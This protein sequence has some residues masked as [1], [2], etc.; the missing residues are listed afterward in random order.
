MVKVLGG[1][2]ARMLA[3]MLVAVSVVVLMVGVLGGS[4]SGQSAA[5]AEFPDLTAPQAAALASSEFPSVV[6]DPAF[7]EPA[8]PAGGQLAFLDDHSANVVAADGSVAGVVVSSVPLRTLND[9]GHPA[10]VD[11]SLTDTGPTLEPAN[12]LVDVRVHQNLVGGVDLGGTGITLVPSGSTLASEGV[13][14][15]AVAFFANAGSDTDFLVK[16]VPAGFESFTA[17]R[18]SDSPTEVSYRFQTPAGVTAGVSGDGLRVEFRGVDGRLVASVGLPSAVDGDGNPVATSWTLDGETM[19][20]SVQHH[21]AGVVYPV[22]V[23]PEVEYEFEDLDATGWTFINPSG[24]DFHG[25]LGSGPHGR[26]LYVRTS[27]S[28]LGLPWSPFS[29]GQR[30]YWSYQ[31]QGTAKITEAEWDDLFHDKDNPQNRS[32]VQVGI[33]QS[34]LSSLWE[35]GPNA[36]DERCAKVTGQEVETS[37]GTGE[38][39]NAALAHPGNAARFGVRIT[40]SGLI[41]SFTSDVGDAEI[42]LTDSDNPTITEDDVPSAWGPWPA[43][44]IVKVSAHDGGLGVKTASLSRSGWNAGTGTSVVPA[45]CQSAA[46]CAPDYLFRLAGNAIPTVANLPAGDNVLTAS[47]TDPEQHTTSQQ[48][49]VR[50]DRIAPTLALSGALYTQRAQ[51][52]APG[53]YQL[54][55]DATDTDPPRTTS[56]VRSLSLTLDGQSIPGAAT[57]TQA[58]AAGSC[59]LGHLFTLDLSAVSGGAHTLVVSATDGAGLTTSQTLA[60]TFASTRVSVAPSTLDLTPAA[61]TT[62]EG[63][64][65]GGLPGAP[66]A[67]QARVVNTGSAL[68]LGAGL[69][70]ENLTGQAARVG[71]YFATIETRPTPSGAWSAIGSRESHI[72]GYSPHDAGPTGAAL[73]LA[74]TPLTASGVTYPASGDALAGTQLA[75]G[76]KGSWS[77]AASISLTGA[78][79]AALLDAAAHGAVRLRVHSELVSSAGTRIA[80]HELAADITGD[81]IT[82]DGAIDHASVQLTALDGSA[83]SVSESTVAALASI[84][85]G[86]Q[87]LIPLPDS[88]PAV[89][90]KTS[91]E[92]DSAYSARLT[93][94]DGQSFAFHATPAASA[95]GTSTR[96]TSGQPIAGPARPLALTALNSSLTRHL[97]VLGIAKIG[98]DAAAPDTDVT[99]TVSLANSGSAAAS[100]GAFT[101]S[102]AGGPPAAISGG[103]ATLS[104]SGGQGSASVP[105]HIPANRADGPLSDTASVAWDDAQGNHYGPLTSSWTTTV[106]APVGVHA[107]PL[108]MTVP[109]T[110]ADATSFLYTGASAVQHG[111]AAG[112]ITP[113]RASVIRG[114]VLDAQGAPLAGVTVRVADHPE[115]GTSTSQVD[116]EIYLAVN[117]GGPLTVRLTKDGYLAVERVVQVPWADY[118]QLDDDV[119]LTA[120]DQNVT[121]VQLG[122]LSA[123]QVARGSVQTDVAG[124]R[125]ATLIFPQ[126]TSASLV[127]PDGSQQPVTQ[128][129]VR[130]TEY[131]VG[132]NGNQAMPGMLPPQSA[133]TYAAD[134]TADEAIA[135]GARSIEF[136]RPVAGY[137]ENFLGFPVGTPVPS[138]YYDS[139]KHAWVAQPDGRVI[140]VLSTGGGQATIDVDGSGNAATAAQLS[141]LGVDA[142]ELTRLASLYT[143]GQSLWRTPMTHFTPY[144]WNFAWTIATNDAIEPDIQT[145]VQ[146]VD[147]PCHA[148]GSDIEC[149][150]QTLGEDHDLA[151]TP[152]SLDYRSS[153]TIG[154]TGENDTL[155]LDVT[156]ASIPSG[157]QAVNATVEVAGRVFRR[158]FA[159]AP[160]LSW[161]LTW[162]RKDA[163]GRRVQGG[164]PATVSVSYAYPVRYATV[165][166]DS[167]CGGGAQVS[168]FGGFRSSTSLGLNDRDQAELASQA[169]ST[170]GGWD[171]TAASDALGG[172]TLDSHHTYDPNTRTA[173]LGDGGKQSATSVSRVV[174]PLATVPGAGNRPIARGPDGSIYAIAG[175]QWNQVYRVTPAGAVQLLAGDAQNGFSGD[176]PTPALQAQFG[177]LLGIAVGPDGSVYVSDYG[178]RRVRKISAQG[179][180]T[181][182]AGNGTLGGPEQGPALSVGF[183]AP[184]GLDVAPDGTLYVSIVGYFY[185]GHGGR[186]IKVTPD[187]YASRFVGRA[188]GDWY[189][190][191]HGQVAS[192][193]STDS[194]TD[195]AVMPDGSLLVADAGLG[196]VRRITQDGTATPFAGGGGSLGDGGPATSAQLSYIYTVDL[197]PDGSVYLGTNG[198]IRRVLPDGTITTVAGNGSMVSEAA[199]K[200]GTPAAQ[201]RVASVQGLATGA[202]GAVYFTDSSLATIVRIASPMPGIS[203]SDFVVPSADGSEVYRFNRQ[204]RHLGTVDALT[205]QTVETFAYDSAGRLTSS[206]D[207]DGN[208]TAIERSPTGVASGILGPYGERTL[209]SHD[210]NGHLAQITDPGGQATALNVSTDGLLG[211]L[212]DPR[213][214]V[215]HFDYDAEGRLTKDSGP[216]GAFSQLDRVVLSGRSRKVTLTS[217]MGRATEHRYARGS[218]DAVTRQTTTPDGLTSSSVSRADG[219]ISATSPDGTQS[220]ATQAADPRFGMQVP[221]AAQASLTTPGGLSITSSQTRNAA[222]TNPDDPL[223]LTS[224]TSTATLSGSTVQGTFTKSTLTS[225]TTSPSGRT[226]SARTDGQ[227]RPVQVSVPG[228][229]PTTFHYDARG[230][231]DQVSQGARTSGLGYDARGRVASSTDP[232]GRT[233]YYGYDTSDRL[234]DEQLP[235]GAHVGFEYDA[236]GNLTGVTPPSRPKHA[237]RFDAADRP[238]RYTPPA[239]GTGTIETKY[240][241]NTDHQPTKVTRANGDVID[242]GYDSAGRAS[243]VTMPGR[244][245]TLGYDSAGRLGSSELT[246]GEHVAFGYDGSFPTS[247]TFTG[248]VAGSTSRTYDTHGRIATTSLNGSPI[249]LSYDA[250]SLLTGAG[251]LTLTRDSQNGLLTGST[252]GSVSTSLTRDGFG[253]PLTLDAQASASGVFHESLIRDNLGRIQ[254]KTE[255]TSSGSHVTQYTYTPDGQLEDVTIDGVLS[256]HY[257]YDPN[258]NRV[259]VTRGVFSTGSTYD[260]QDRLTQS[261]TTSYSYDQ[262]GDLT[263]KTD[264]SSGQSTGY[265]YDAAGDLTRVDLPD[266]RVVSYT[267]DSGGNRI[268]RKVDGTLTQAFL[269]GRGAQGPAAQLDSTGSVVSRFV[270]ATSSVVPDYMTRSGVTYRIVRDDLGSPRLVIDTA[271]GTVAERMD[272]DEYGRTLTDTNPGLIPFGYAGGL[273]DP[274]TGLVRMGARD[275]NPETGRWTTKDPIA[276]AGGDTSLYAYVGGDPINNTDPGGLSVLDIVG[277]ALSLAERPINWAARETGL[278]GLA[279]NA[280]EFYVGAAN[281]PNASWLQRAGATTLGLFSSLAACDNAGATALTLAGGAGGAVRGAAKAGEKGLDGASRTY[282]DITRSKSAIRNIGTDATHTEFA[283]NLTAQG[284]SSRVVGDGKATLFE[285]D[286][287]RYSLREDADSYHGWTAD[288]TPAGARQ[289]TLKIRLG[290]P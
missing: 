251:P 126:D 44:R 172:W 186:V 241:Y 99:Y 69:G 242:L 276:F 134:F 22:L 153:R 114:R 253:A 108:D 87:A 143:A 257:A 101:D 148:S 91:G 213:G 278:T 193:T 207:G 51:T 155:D 3:L 258:G 78:Q 85:P 240:D 231:L 181:T 94:A 272:F 290:W 217:A 62:L 232:A 80:E 220:T 185:S 249:T 56:G 129:H 82:Q 23:D 33:A 32:C 223:S 184:A 89:A 268:E 28:L 159:P 198:R 280:L 179:V 106:Q 162:D 73:A 35:P 178:N 12:P 235:G 192:D 177:L 161:H 176:G 227:G 174:T 132:A 244:A 187:G 204:G 230:R 41:G 72:G 49:H 58:C 196:L 130:A 226:S 288:Y 175:N 234:V 262:A 77:A 100:V 137:V 43:S 65:P 158:S 61:T 103:P 168:R 124:S 188:D 98:P 122:V 149:E 266:G 13:A 121:P 76:A 50:I 265:H 224:L 30:A 123:P 110:V 5:P 269:Y 24:A 233:T 261:G 287:A 75:A 38:H 206:A 104:A 208:V 21:A 97:P 254:S 10:P 160:N 229:T 42:R 34:A 112:T 64:Q 1:R 271:T 228:I 237:F 11:L 259:S 182:I 140:K 36:F 157:L 29:D 191:I 95:S 109:T 47:A 2:R 20:V 250:D 88:V 154:R 270:Y 216:A 282:I 4:A 125:Q 150:N 195:V 68:R 263:G 86:A 197:A 127:L 194:V 46:V 173:Y 142:A 131:T 286:G 26:G 219:S 166:C 27:Q 39:G 8:V 113:K 277:D 19:R 209:L 246:G 255:T 53:S 59:P 146:N 135:A 267:T 238:D 163:F 248:P 214:S 199:G 120:L 136:S 245:V 189:S 145:P 66:V 205:G 84:A 15:G 275:Y 236:N 247:E 111:M 180:V 274:D 105:F 60:L 63:E 138:G 115:Y 284:W 211:S 57:F 212:T 40:G 147:D 200:N 221:F 152:H 79:T 256:A 190:S 210:T 170:V 93:A 203:D 156:P 202:D 96:N 90:A 18:S 183:P 9:A 201:V 289:T 81:V 45:S 281:D 118:A 117:G 7:T 215:H 31:A 107:P 151:G 67:Y 25:T 222:L 128:L 116:G 171:A 92:S 225:G 48:I 54:Q 119:R 17:L 6:V 16:P 264:S 55:A 283:D 164:Q 260:D 169:T 141:S 273:K 102:V 52:L 71:S 165:S 252:L 70:V 243:T 279:N 74:L 144:D 133:Y 37:V 285:K 83:R 239:A 218:D 14:Q 167:G 139:G